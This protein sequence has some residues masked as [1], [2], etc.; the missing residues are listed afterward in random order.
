MTGAGRALHARPLI[1]GLVLPAVLA[2]PR[3]ARAQTPAP[4]LRADSVFAD[5]DTPTTPGCALAVVRDGAPVYERGYGMANLEYGIPITPH[6]VFHVASVS[7][8][9][10]A[11]AVELLVNDGKVSWSD[12]VRKYVPEVPDFGTPITLRH[13]VHHVSGIRDQ[14]DLLSMAGWRWEADVVTERDVLDITS[15]QTALNFPPGERYL[16]SNTGFTLLAVVVERVSGESLRAFTTKRIFAPLGM[17]ETHFHDDHEMIVRN[18][19]WAYAPDPDGLYGLKNSVPDFDVVG[20]TSLFTTVH[21]M[22][23]WDRNF[24][25]GKVGGRAALERMHER[26]VLDS[27]DTITYMHG[28]VAGRYRGLRTVSHSGAD[29]GYRSAFLRFPDQ[30]LTVVT[31]C[32]FPSADPMGRSYRVADVYLG[33]VM[34]P[35]AG[36]GATRVADEKT[37]PMSAAELRP[38]AGAYRGEL[39]D[40]VVGIS[41]DG[42][43]LRAG[44]HG[45]P[46][47]R[48]LGNGRFEVTGVGAVVTLRPPADGAPATLVVPGSGPATRVDA[49]VPSADE[50][51]A[52][53]GTYASDELGTDYRVALEE[54]GL[55]VHHRTL[56]DRELTPTFRDAFLLDGASAVFT[57][58]AAGAVDGFSLSDGRVWNVRFRRAAAP[59]D[60]RIGYTP[61]ECASCAGWNAAHAPVRV[62]GSTYWVGTAGLGAVLITSEEGHVLIDG[63]L[64]E[65][66]PRILESIRSLGFRI[67]DV[68]VILNSHTHYDHAGGIAALQRASGARVVARGPSAAVL[69]RGAPGPDDPQYRSALPFPPVA[70]VDVVADGDTVRVGPLA[71][72]A[73]ATPGHT[74]GGTTWSWRA[75]EGGRCLD[76]VYADSETP[77]SDDGFRFTDGAAYPDAVA[78][79]ERGFRTL[80]ALPCDVLVTPHPAVSGWWERVAA[81]DRGDPNALVDPGACRAYAAR[82]RAQLA[83]RLERERGG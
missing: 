9:F 57:R 30:R 6:S 65:S 80:E 40:Q 38:L 53:V 42:D 43:T 39:P 58:D 60:G 62:F 28:L 67:E 51:R 54:G 76:L 13:L 11:M 41:L 19:A 75:C 78:D 12:D 45:G 25:T 56:D 70:R 35:R 32:N 74:P 34:E 81:R 20:A 24:I 3:P 73:H 59:R 72:V 49:W 50:L 69:E 29:A 36:S 27:G 37:V 44:F 8:E 68:R 52:F 79:F 14:W 82:S 21:D 33:D 83:A 46:A 2:A 1:V 5:V 23:A 31:L 55:V 26:F 4:E 22:A 77:I 71:L 64:P 61:T 16:Y 10:T 7:K 15:R 48:P 17:D 47:L 18:R 66:A 63:A